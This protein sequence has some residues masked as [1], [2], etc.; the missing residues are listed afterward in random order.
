MAALTF[1]NRL[2]ISRICNRSSLDSTIVKFSSLS[3][4]RKV[5][6]SLPRL[7]LRCPRAC[8]YVKPKERKGPSLKS[9]IIFG[10]G[11]VAVATGA[12]IYVGKRFFINTWKSFRT[13][14]V[15]AISVM[16]D[17]QYLILEIAS[18][19]NTLHV[20]TLYY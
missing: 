11:C 12:V 15:I 13:S 1:C 17:V 18:F 19:V 6:R 16:T 8:Y 20:L 7:P 2:L 3:C 4:A 14:H 9:W 10:A 5:L